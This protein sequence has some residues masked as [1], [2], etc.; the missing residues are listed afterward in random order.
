MQKT[1]CQI[2]DTGPALTFFINE[3][4]ANISFGVK[5]TLMLESHEKAGAWLTKATL[6]VKYN[7]ELREVKLLKGESTNV[8]EKLNLP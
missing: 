4:L 7:V 2:S 6:T 8:Q 5:L 1:V 3:Y